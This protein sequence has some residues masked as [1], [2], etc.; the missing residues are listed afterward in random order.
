MNGMLEIKKESVDDCVHLPVMIFQF[1]DRLISWL[2]DP[3]IC[4]ISWN[5]VP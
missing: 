1:K 2:L 3:E 5:S 4:S